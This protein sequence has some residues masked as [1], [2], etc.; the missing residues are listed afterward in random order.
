VVEIEEVS[1]SLN[2]A[3]L[4]LIKERSQDGV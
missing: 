4:A 1:T 3:V 2:E